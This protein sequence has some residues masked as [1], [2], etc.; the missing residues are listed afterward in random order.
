ML[1]QASTKF[2]TLE[3]NAAI[4]AILVRP[5]TRTFYLFSI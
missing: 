1:Y 2:E 4:L 3:F 5:I